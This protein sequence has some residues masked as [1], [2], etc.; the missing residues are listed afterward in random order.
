MASFCIDL[1]WKPADYKKLAVRDYQAI[2]QLAEARA[3]QD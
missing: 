1:H 3:D 2:T